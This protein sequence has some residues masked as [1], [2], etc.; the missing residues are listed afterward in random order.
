MPAQLDSE[1]WGHRPSAEL[2]KV[3]QLTFPGKLECDRQDLA[4]LS[5]FR[6]KEWILAVHIE[7]PDRYDT[8]SDVDRSAQPIRAVSNL[9]YS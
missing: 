5:R 2:G 7:R 4:S 6:G 8:D 3:K 1:F 9:K